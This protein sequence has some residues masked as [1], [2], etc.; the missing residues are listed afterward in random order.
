MDT[1]ALNHIR[2]HLETASAAVLA[3]LDAITDPVERQDTARE[4][5][6]ILLPAV[7][8]EV[9]AHRAG[10]VAQLQ[11]TLTLTEVG[12]LI[13]GLSAARVEQILKGK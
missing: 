3:A 11:G 4:V 6:Q 10:T 7:G 8:Q 1:T 5:V 13:G 2:G 12:E 9:K